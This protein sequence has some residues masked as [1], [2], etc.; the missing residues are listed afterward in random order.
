MV[1]PLWFLTIQI[2][3]SLKLLNGLCTV[4]TFVVMGVLEA[5]PQ[6]Q[7]Y[8]RQVGCRLDLST[9]MQKH[10]NVCT[11]MYTHIHEYTHARAHTHTYAHTHTRTHAHTHTRT[12]THNIYMHAHIR[13]HA[14][15]HTGACTHT[16]PCI[17]VRICM[18]THTH[19]I[20]LYFQ[21]T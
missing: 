11:Y 4:L 3:H 5:G 14:Y 10:T 17:H 8:L 6:F 19:Q 2:C 1:R 16:H 13:M 12:R 18:D 9:I 20:D 21:C 15:T 7:I